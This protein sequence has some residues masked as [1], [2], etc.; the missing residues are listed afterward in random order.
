MGARSTNNRQRVTLEPA[1]DSTTTTAIAQRRTIP[2]GDAKTIVFI[3]AFP[4][5]TKR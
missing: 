1:D 2:I 5:P 3:H 4:C